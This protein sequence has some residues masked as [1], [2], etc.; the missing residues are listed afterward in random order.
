MNSLNIFILFI[1]MNLMISLAPEE[2][3]KHEIIDLDQLNVDIT[4]DNCQKLITSLVNLVKYNYVFTDIAKDPPNEEY[5]GIVDLITDLEGIEIKGRKYYDFYR[6]VKRVIN[7]VRDLHFNLMAKNNTENGIQMT[8]IIMCIPFSLNVRGDSPENAEMY[9]DKFV[10]LSEFYSEDDLN[11]IKNHVNKTITKINDISP[12]D[13]IQNFSKGLLSIKSK[14][15]TFSLLLSYFNY[16]QLYFIPLNKTEISNIK[17]T[18]ADGES[19]T[20]NYTVVY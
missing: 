11:F 10:N 16:F 8:K 17:F 7:K 5:Y 12:F 18:F 3:Y 9:M 14:H 15:G 20:L 4:E 13:Y 6:E 1:S 19:V 2:I